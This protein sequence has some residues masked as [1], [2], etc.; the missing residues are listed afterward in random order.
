MNRSDNK[1]LISSVPEF[2]VLTLDFSKGILLD[3]LISKSNVRNDF[4]IFVL[5]AKGNAGIKI[6]LKAERLQK[7]DLLIIPPDATQERLYVSEDAVLKIIAFTSDFLMQLNLPSGFWDITDYYSTK[8]TPVWSLPKSAFKRLD[9][10]M[11]QLEVMHTDE[12]EHPYSKE[13]LNFTFMIFILELAA[14]APKYALEN[15]QRLTRKELLTVQFYALAK[16]NFHDQRELKFYADALFVTP[17]H[18]TETVKEVSKRTAGET[19]DNFIIQ[20]AKIQLRTTSKSIAEISDALQFSDQSSFGKF[21]KRITG[22]SPTT[23]RNERS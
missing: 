21:F 5:I 22:V 2:S 1:N 3:D 10:L 7:N 19:I 15:N 13:I 14:L 4:F 8:H 20:E 6:N 11:T 17:K 9:S 23:Y 18:L 16:K 12:Q